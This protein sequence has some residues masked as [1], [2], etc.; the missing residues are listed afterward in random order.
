MFF[1]LPQCF[2]PR[3]SWL[4]LLSPGTHKSK[5]AKE[6]TLWVGKAIDFV[7]ASSV[8]CSTNGAWSSSLSCPETAKDNL[9]KCSPADLGNTWS[10]AR[11]SS[12]CWG[13]K[14]LG[15][16]WSCKDEAPFLLPLKDKGQRV[17]CLFKSPKLWSGLESSPR[18]P[19][20]CSESLFPLGYCWISLM[21]FF[22]KLLLSWTSKSCPYCGEL[23]REIVV[24]P[25]P[26]PEASVVRNSS[27][28]SSS[29]LDSP[30]NSEEWDAIIFLQVFDAVIWYGSHYFHVQFSNLAWRR[31]FLK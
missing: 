14:A 7:R 24:R 26:V 1:L 10:T 17:D 12:C 29:L 22:S 18:I 31:L 25:Q 9:Y 4:R 2:P 13:L 6:S 20:P 8:A 27:R 19:E 5:W 30:Y 28:V 11:Y 16:V 21:V 15:V 3:V 23:W